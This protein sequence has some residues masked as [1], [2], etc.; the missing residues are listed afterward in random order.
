MSCGAPAAAAVAVALCAPAWPANWEIA[1][2]VEAGYRYN[3]N[4]RL[5]QPGEEVEVS[6]AEVDARATFRTIDPRTTFEITPRVRAT[7]F[8]DERDEDYTDY[9]LSG[10]F[11]DV[12]PRRRVGV[13]AEAT[14]ETVVRSELRDAELDGELGVP[15]DPDSGRVRE[16]A[17][18]DLLRVA[19]FFSYALSERYL[20]QFDA[21]LLDAS[22]SG[23]S[24]GAYQDF[25]EYNLGAGVGV[26]TSERSSVLLRAFGS[27]YETTFDSE[28]YGAELRWTTDFSPTSRAYVSL[29]G[30][31]TERDGGESQSGLVGGLGGRWTSQRNEFFIDLMRSVRAIGAGTIVERHQLRLGIDHA[32]S[33]RLGLQL[34]VRA[35]RDEELEDVG[36]Y[37]TREYA[38]A[39][40]GLEWR[41]TRFVSL[42]A[43]YNYYW[44]EYEDEPSDASA[45]SFLIGLVYEPKRRD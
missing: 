43:T 19:P 26:Q 41:W 14:R 44:Q 15:D 10:L 22:Y 39:Q 40:A 16:R 37:P 31:Q 13:R 33:P 8:P 3:D 20:V 24:R 2:R 42:R 45:N 29:G 9:L 27:R 32:V 38:S 25:N 35:N 34:A 28:G 30:Q 11:Q 1:P 18:R 7:H 17:D 6:G 4:H 12:T 23:A 21:S 36:T 5:D